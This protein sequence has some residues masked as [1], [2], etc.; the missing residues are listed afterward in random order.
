VLKTR[1]FCPYALK[2][3]K[4]AVE[5]V[6]LQFHGAS[7]LSISMPAYSSILCILAPFKMFASWNPMPVWTLVMTFI[8]NISCWIYI[9]NTHTHTH[10][11]TH[12]TGKSPVTSSIDVI[13]LEKLICHGY[14][15]D[16]ICN[17]NKCYFL[18]NILFENILK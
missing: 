8:T 4:A 12:E 18:K 1:I 16:S 6:N 11:H 5:E 7:P 9:Y 13:L 3:L 2:F 15:W 17:G 14:L 10:T